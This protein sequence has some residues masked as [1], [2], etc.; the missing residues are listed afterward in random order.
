MSYNLRMA[1]MKN[2]TQL[3][4]WFAISYL[5]VTE[6]ANKQFT[7]TTFLRMLLLSFFVV[8][9]TAFTQQHQRTHVSIYFDKTSC[10][11]GFP[12]VSN[13]VASSSTLSLTNGSCY[14]QEEPSLCISIDEGS[15]QANPSTVLRQDLQVLWGVIL[16]LLF[17]PLPAYAET[18]RPNSMQIGNDA[19]IGTILSLIGLFFSV[20]FFGYNILSSET[21]ANIN[22]VKTQLK[23]DIDSLENKMENKF[24]LIESKF[25]VIESKFT[26]IESKLTGIEGNIKGLQYAI[27]GFAAVVLLLVF[28]V[29]S[30]TPK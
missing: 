16:V 29:P 21:E 5:H 15:Q 24:T 22:S 19:Y 30:M 7:M 12:R 26:G 2:L 8:T 18:A 1:M 9:T 11:E 27:A 17:T 14:P 6:Q 13:L 20:N 23:A 28:G 10:R 3:D 4:L 25:T